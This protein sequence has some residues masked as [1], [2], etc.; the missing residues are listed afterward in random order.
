MS[1]LMTS[2]MTCVSSREARVRRLGL[3]GFW[4]SG[5]WRRSLNVHSL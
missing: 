2:L 5:T 1:V 4:Q 3:S